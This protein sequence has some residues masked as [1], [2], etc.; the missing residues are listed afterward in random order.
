MSFFFDFFTRFKKSNS[1]DKY[2][3]LN[4]FVLLRTLD[5]LPHPQYR[6]LTSGFLYDFRFPINFEFLHF[7]R[8]RRAAGWVSS[9]GVV[10]QDRRISSIRN[11][12]FES[13]AFP[14]S[15]AEMKVRTVRLWDCDI[16]N[17]SSSGEIQFSI[18]S[19]ARLPSRVRPWAKL[20]HDKS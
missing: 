19:S 12:K 13:R 10:E 16:C 3:L 11:R 15:D 20:T 18:F 9:W 7:T 2:F 1:D 6:H 5:S 8:V 14:A 17:I 4:F